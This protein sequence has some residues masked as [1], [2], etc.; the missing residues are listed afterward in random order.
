MVC[1]SAVNLCNP[2]LSF[3]PLPIIYPVVKVKVF[4]FGIYNEL[5][6]YITAA[7]TSKELAIDGSTYSVVYNFGSLG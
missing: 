7:N 6:I 1:H 4:S 2:L 3:C 5:Y